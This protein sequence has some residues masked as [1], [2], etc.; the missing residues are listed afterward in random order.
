MKTGFFSWKT[1]M[2]AVIATG[3]LFISGDARQN[4]S[5][6]HPDHKKEKPA[7]IKHDY[8]EVN[9]VRLHYARAGKG[10]L[11]MFV[12]GFPEFWYE[13][14]NQ[15]G[16]FGRLSRGSSR[17]AGYNLSSKPASGNEV[18]LWSKTSPHLPKSLGTSLFWSRTIG[19]AQ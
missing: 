19:A 13:W 1:P 3:F 2:F 18:K 6:K 16:E 11:I 15:L 12:H 17:Y 7:M 9:G 10:K 14:K 5:T 4:T 8:A